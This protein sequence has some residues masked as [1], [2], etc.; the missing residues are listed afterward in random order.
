MTD[1][2]AHM[3]EHD[4]RHQQA[5]VCETIDLI[6]NGAQSVCLSSPTGGGKSRMMVRLAQWGLETGRPVAIYTPRKL[7]TR[8]LVKTFSEWSLPFGVR[9][10]GF[11]EWENLS[12][13]IQICS[14]ATEASR[15]FRLAGKGRDL[16]A[17]GLAIWDEVHMQKGQSAGKIRAAHRLA[18]AADVGV[19][20]TPLGIG[21]IYGHLVL[22]GTNRELR[23]C[24]SH[25]PC[26]VVAPDEPDLKDITRRKAGEIPRNDDGEFVLEKGAVSLWLQTVVGRVLDHWRTLN[27]DQRPTI[28]FA[29]GV[30]E[31]RWFVDQFAAIGVRAA[32]IDGDDVYLDGVSKSLKPEERDG[33]L[34]QVRSGEIKV[35]CNRFVMREGIDLPELY[36]CILATPIGSLLS[37]VQTVGRVLRFHAS[38]P[39]HVIVQDHGGNWHRHGSPNEDRSRLWRECFRLP[40]RVASSLRTERMREGKVNEPIHCPKCHAIRAAGPECHECGHRPDKRSRVVVQTDG[41]L[42]DVTTRIAPPRRVRKLADTEARWKSIYHRAKRSRNGMTFAQARGLFVRENGYTPPADLPYMPARDIDWYRKVRDVPAERLTGWDATLRPAAV[43]G[44]R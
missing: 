30:D 22:A 23:E 9:A 33:V 19:T 17:A 32:H 44:A 27:P 36:H 10:A 7:L 42:R 8:Q 21:D 4:W 34:D 20:A 5:G 39:G 16:H 2:R 41:Q 15:V 12:A 11:G 31:S 37:Y 43:G 3:L 38:L 26:R 18:G 35:I 40:V 24:G 6:A 13:P 28:L 14:T 25:L 29:P 1:W